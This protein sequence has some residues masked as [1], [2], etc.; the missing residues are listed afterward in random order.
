MISLYTKHRLELLFTENGDK[1][2]KKDFALDIELYFPSTFNNSK[3]TTPEDIKCI[4]YLFISCF[5]Y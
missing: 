4:V 2:F 5:S 1:Q 3:I